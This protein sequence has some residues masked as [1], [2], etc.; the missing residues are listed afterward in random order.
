L[1]PAAGVFA[2]W[3]EVVTGVS[4][5]RINA[6]YNSAKPLKK[7]GLSVVIFFA[8]IAFFFALYWTLRLTG[9]IPNEG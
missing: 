4:I 1:L 7:M 9:Q 3:L 2:G 5:F 8:V 6:T